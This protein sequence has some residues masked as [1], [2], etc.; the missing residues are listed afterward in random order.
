MSVL[1]RTIGRY[2]VIAELGQGGMS[3]VY[4]AHD[5]RFGRDVAVKLLPAAF[6]H[7]PTFRARFEREARTIAALEHAAIV[8]VYDFGE[9]EDQPYLVMRLMAGGTLADRLRHGPLSL[10]G[11]TAILER[12]GPALDKAHARGIVHRDLKPANILF[13][14]DGN[15]FLSDFGIVKVTEAPTALTGSHIVG[16][17]AY[18]SPEQAQGEA[19]LD[20]RSDV[21]ALGAILFEM[22]TGE[23]PYQADTPM[24]LVVKQITEPTPRLWDTRPDLPPGCDSVIQTA[25][26]KNRE[27]RYAT[28][29]AMSA[30]LAAVAAEPPVSRFGR[31]KRVRRPNSG[32]A[33]G[34][35][36]AELPVSRSGKSGH[37]AVDEFGWPLPAEPLAE[38]P[39]SAGRRAPL[40]VWGV[41]A[42]ALLFLAAA[43]LF[44][45]YLFWRPDQPTSVA[46]PSGIPTTAA[47]GPPATAVVAGNIVTVT[48]TAAATDTPAATTPT[49]TAGPAGLGTVEARR[50]DS[51]PVIDGILAEWDGY[52]AV[53]SSFFVH[54]DSNWNGSEDLTAVWRLGWDNDY[55]YVAV[56]VGD[57]R[58]VQTQSGDLIFRGDSLD[59]Q[60]DTDLTGDYGTGLSPDDFQIIFS[61]GDFGALPPSVFRFTANADGQIVDAPDHN[62]VLAAQPAG[63][64]YILEAA[65]PWADLRV[66][67]VPG[68]ALGL[69]LNANDNDRPGEAVQEVM[70]SNVAGRTLTNP[71]SW[72]TLTLR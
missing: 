17:P 57:D 44:G 41:A 49:A 35:D 21:Y 16:T 18:M 71:A 67:A 69:A 43:G 37:D 56:E 70:M 4:R 31:A 22:L 30:A 63:Q 2:Q 3:T 32:F 65:I 38:R 29:G 47:T 48:E 45:L 62:I 5:P 24:G 12:I 64:G 52:P 36:A 72:G 68:L 7:R 8:P 1:P 11:A 40:W 50:R 28:A 23:P 15:A 55:L 14:Q 51:Q 13:D 9:H 39:G 19:S 10:Q 34:H 66:T 54:S 33:S 60:I 46:L 53:A 6:L 25:M 59:M 20:G 58:H 27:Q 61:P 42:V 26:A